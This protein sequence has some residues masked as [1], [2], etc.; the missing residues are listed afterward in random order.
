LLLV[1]LS[2]AAHPGLASG[3]DEVEVLAA[4]GALVAWPGQDLAECE[5]DGATW[6]PLPEG[7]W[8]AVDLLESRDRIQVSRRGGAG[9]EYAW[10]RVAPYPYSEQHIR[11][12]DDSRVDLSPAD[13]ER[14]RREQGRVASLWGSAGPRRFALPL[15]SPLRE[16]GSGGRFGS[17]RF[18]NGQPRS[19]HSGA[20]YPAPEGT[21]VFAAAAGR[22][23]LAD[24]LFFS[25]GSIFIDHGDGLVSMYFHLSEV[26]VAEGAEVTRGQ[27]IGRVGQ[28]GRATGPHLHFGARWRRARVD[29]EQLLDPA[30]AVRI[31][32]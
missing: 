17:R 13:L 3:L 2:W 20:D 12:E 4:P 31:G 7:C 28:T 1:V 23:A 26:Q 11:L 8:F 19:P 5:M 16:R 6:A 10:I 30:S 14:V 21:D 18:F 22:V 29:P 27:L 32:E 15:A 24:D 9:D 25:G